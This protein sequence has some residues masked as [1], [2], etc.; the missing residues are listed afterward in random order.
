MTSR[1]FSTAVA[2]GSAV[3]AAGGKVAVG[4]SVGD[5]GVAVDEGVI[6]GDCVLAIGGASV[7]AT[8]GV[9]IPISWLSVQPAR[10][11]S[12]Q[13]PIQHFRNSIHFIQT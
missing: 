4:V 1:C 13:I 2:V 11:H 9:M 12:Q 7:A 8:S 5:R 10:K 3:A 6:V